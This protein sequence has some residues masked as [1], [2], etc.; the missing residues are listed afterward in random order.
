M[1]QLHCVKWGN[2]R[3]GHYKAVFTFTSVPNKNVVLRGGANEHDWWHHFGMQLCANLP[4][5]LFILFTVCIE[6]WNSILRIGGTRGLFILQHKLEVSLKY[7]Q[8]WAGAGYSRS[9]INSQEYPWHCIH[10]M[11][12]QVSMSV[13]FTLQETDI[14]GGNYS[15]PHHQ[16]HTQTTGLFWHTIASKQNK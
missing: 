7:S 3:T 12:G 16:T 11:S 13:L 15:T 8:K 9:S 5:S 2:C 1:F 4:S 14:Y 6:K 10:Y